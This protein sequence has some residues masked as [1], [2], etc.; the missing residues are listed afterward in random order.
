MWGCAAGKVK[1]IEGENNIWKNIIAMGW[2]YDL[3]HPSE[4]TEE[5]RLISEGAAWIDRTDHKRMAVLKTHRLVYN[6]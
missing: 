6:K 1:S 4:L 5:E 3:K 2:R